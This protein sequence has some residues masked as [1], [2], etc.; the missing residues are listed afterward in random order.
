LSVGPKASDSL[1]GGIDSGIGAASA[2]AGAASAKATA[3]ASA[4][5]GAGAAA[6]TAA[7]GPAGTVLGAAA[8][9]AAKLAV[10]PVVKGAIV[11]VLFLV[12][13]FSSIPSMFFENPMDM[14]DN[15]GPQAVYQKFKDYVMEAYKVEIENRKKDIERDFQRRIASGEF[16]S[17]DHVECSYSFDP[18]EEVFLT[19]VRESCVLIIAMFE[20]HTDDWR[21]AS[22][23]HFQKTINSVRFWQGVVETEKLSETSTVTW[24]GCGEDEDPESTIHVEMTYRFHDKGVEQFRKKFGLQDDREYLKSVEMAYNTK[25]LFGEAADLPLGGVTGGASGSYPGGGTHNT[26]RQALAELGEKKEFFGGPAGMPLR[27][28]LAVTSEFG[29]R[30]YAPD[31]IHTG[32]DFSAGAGTP[33]YAAM[34]GIVLLRLNNPR[35]FGNHILLYHGGEVTTMYAHLSAFGSCRVGDQ[36]KRGEVVGYVGS[37]GLSTGNHLHFEYQKNG[38]AYDPKTI[39]PI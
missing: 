30:N 20:V 13:V 26:I 24:S 31:P 1:E 9:F 34:G 21:K 33:V 39:L 38:A 12:M 17:Y 35:T 10:S 4:A 6:G 37:T 3:S 27:S 5:A 19:E 15:T 29:P 14:A 11:L 23:D 8:G 7:G 2:F 28:Y 16:S 18:A 22:L 32:I 25:V 36:V